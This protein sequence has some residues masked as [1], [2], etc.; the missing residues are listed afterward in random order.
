MFSKLYSSTNPPQFTVPR[1]PKSGFNRLSFLLPVEMLT[2]KFD[3]QEF[4][5]GTPLSLVYTLARNTFW[6]ML[7]TSLNETVSQAK[8]HFPR[9]L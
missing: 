1:V 7:I 6:A 3:G 4:Q 5:R 2:I 9:S 8:G